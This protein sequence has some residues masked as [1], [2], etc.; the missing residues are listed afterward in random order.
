[1][2]SNRRRLVGKQSVQSMGRPVLNSPQRRR[3]VGKQ[4]VQA[5]SLLQAADGEDTG[6]VVKM[7]Y[8]VTLSHP[9]TAKTLS[10]DRIFDMA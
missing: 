2:A 8:S 10:F 6:T 9:K 4:N 5:F 7:V 3:L 1:M